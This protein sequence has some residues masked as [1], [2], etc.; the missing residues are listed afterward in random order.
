M[1]DIAGIHRGRGPFL[2]K[3]LSHMVTRD[4]RSWESVLHS[5]TSHW[6]MQGGRRA[7]S[8][9]ASPLWVIRAPTPSSGPSA[10]LLPPGLPVSLLPLVCVWL[11]DY[12]ASLF[13]DVLRTRARALGKQRAPGTCQSDRY[14][15][16]RNCQRIP[17][18]SSL[19]TLP[20]SKARSQRKDVHFNASVP[21]P[22][23]NNGSCC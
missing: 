2:N 19:W 23:L 21:L 18:I 20:N 13:I 11:A 6:Q 9:G 3:H 5:V 16:P 7:A 22:I 1:L 15:R 4:P 14:T 17:R 10:Y 12:K 8:L